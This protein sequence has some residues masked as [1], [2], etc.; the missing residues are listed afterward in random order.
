MQLGRTTLSKFLI[1]QLH[2]VD[3]NGQLAGL[4]ID[5]AAAMKSI[6]A[7]T[8]KGA[9]GGFH[10]NIEATNIQGEVQKKLDV[11][12]N[13]ALIDACEWGGTLAGM[14]SEENEEPIRIP[15][16]FKRGRYLL[17]FDPLDG[18]SNIDVNVSVGTIFSV[19]VHEKETEP[20][21]GDFLQVGRRQ[22]AAGY[23]IYGPAT[24]LVI[25][26]GKGTHAFT[27]DREIGNFILTHEN[28]VIPPD[29]SEFAINTSNERF[30]EPPVSRYVEECKAGKTGIRG[31][32]FNMRW[33]ASMVA[34]VHRIL[35][36]GGVFMYPRDTK[37]P[38]KPGRLRLLYEAN[39][40]SF[41]IEQAGGAASHGRGPILDHPAEAPHQRIAVI[42]GSKNEVE[43]IERY[44]AEFD[45]GID[46]PYISP[47]FSNRSLY[48]SEAL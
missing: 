28:L 38:K 25:T 22:V 15:P 24:M 13:D 5:V 45:A 18:S 1:E 14:I 35:M 37:D 29:T 17:N 34:E 30:W 16:E 2:E 21:A 31:R 48:R 10:G 32:D 33:I 8:A 20:T 19:L 27:L 3:D 6:A 39:P 26:V 42:F 43:R 7:M 23:A 4:L 46:Q 9:L 11:L 47:L 41:L 12:S 40:V 44:H 36:R